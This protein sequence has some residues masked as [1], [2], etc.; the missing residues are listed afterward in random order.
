MKRECRYINFARVAVMGIGNAGVNSLARISTDDVYGVDLLALNTDVQTVCIP[1]ANPF[2][3]LGHLS[4]KHGTGGDISLGRYAAEESKEI[5]LDTIQKYDMLFLVSGFGGGTGTGATPLIAKMAQQLDILTVGIIYTPFALE[6]SKRAALAYKGIEE[7]R[8]NVDTLIVIPNDRL[9]EIAGSRSGFE[10]VFRLGDEVLIRSIHVIEDVL[11]RP[12]II[13][14]DFADIRTIMKGQGATLFTKGQAS[15]RHRAAEAAYQ[16]TFCPILNMTIQGARHVLLNITGSSDLDLFEI[17]EIV[18]TIQEMVIPGGNFI[19]TTIQ[20]ELLDNTV[21]VMVIASGFETQ[22]LQE[23]HIFRP[24]PTFP[25]SMNSLEDDQSHLQGRKR[26]KF[27]PK[28]NETVE[29]DKPTY[30]YALKT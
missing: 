22:Q 1:H 30:H 4:R 9:A 5:I 7:M 6:G 3:P 16:A 25:I 11:T 23:G 18:A 29:T 28:G 20:D 15:G 17:E 10:A 8:S 27:I 13:N 26:Y 19:F 12:G 21:E 24:Q 2:I 14:A